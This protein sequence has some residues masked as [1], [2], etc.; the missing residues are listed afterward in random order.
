MYAN[1]SSDCHMPVPHQLPLKT[2]LT[3]KVEDQEF[4]RICVDKSYI[5]LLLKTAVEEKRVE[6][7]CDEFAVGTRV[8]LVAYAEQVFHRS[9]TPVAEE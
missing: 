6:R 4:G 8:V 7:R 5:F 9:Q 2:A 3:Q 1:L